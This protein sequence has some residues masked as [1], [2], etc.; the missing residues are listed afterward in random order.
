MITLA[1][2]EKRV[3]QFEKDMNDYRKWVVFY[4]SRSGRYRY[5]TISYCKLYQIQYLPTEYINATEAR[6]AAQ[7]LNIS[8]K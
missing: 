3:E 8:G 4:D 2:F 5:G 7:K 6:A 1:E